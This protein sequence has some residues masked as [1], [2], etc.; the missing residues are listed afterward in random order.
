MPYH[1][2]IVVLNDGE[3]WTTLEGCKILIVDLEK[4]VDEQ[5][6]NGTGV[7]L[8]DIA[9]ACKYHTTTDFER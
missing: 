7:N 6:R 2:Y 3:T 8:S 1:S 5:I 9:S 4:N